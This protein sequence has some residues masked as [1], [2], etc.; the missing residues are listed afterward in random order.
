MLTG[1]LGHQWARSIKEMRYKAK[2]TCQEQVHD[3][4][5][6]HANEELC[7]AIDFRR[8]IIYILILS[9]TVWKPL[10][11]LKFLVYQGTKT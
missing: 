3:F 11:W 7:S 10:A 2:N 6:F 9:I 4:S 1:L 5:M 8:K